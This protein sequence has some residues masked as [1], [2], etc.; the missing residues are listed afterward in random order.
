MNPVSFY[1]HKKI[2]RQ[3]DKILALYNK[4][5]EFQFKA[6]YLNTNKESHQIKV[7]I[8]LAYCDKPYTRFFTST[9][10][11][12]YNF[13]LVDKP[14]LADVVVF[15]NKFDD[16]L[17]RPEQKAIFFYHEPLAYATHYQSE[18]HEENFPKANLQIISHLTT[19]SPFIK[20]ADGVKFHRTIPYIQFHHNATYE[21][22]KTIDNS[23][24]NKLICSIVSALHQ[25]PGH[26]PRREF[27]EN[28]SKA[29]P[30][31]DMYGRFHKLA[32][33]IP[34]YRGPS[35]SKWKALSRYKYNLVIENANE[36]YY[37]SEKVFDALICGCMPIYYGSK[38][39]FEI[40]PKEWFYYLPTLDT[41]EIEKVNAFIAT[42]SYKIISDNRNEISKIIYTKF[43]FYSTLNRL[44]NDENLSI[45]LP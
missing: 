38:K 6:A 37:I 35:T 39:I 22:L 9:D 14:D 1:L 41:S 32:T 19:P 12:N 2:Y 13:N 29:N 34:A 27:L 30:Q 43:S 5:K 31:F 25:I 7:C 26:H 42:D 18:L 44:I 28:F 24:R 17:L 3:Q 20:N 8:V 15:V 11:R 45:D 23:Q 36:D 40:L 21:Q 16:N 4:Y 10:N 33:Q